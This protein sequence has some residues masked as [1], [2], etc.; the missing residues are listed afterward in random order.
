M[1]SPVGFTN[2]PAAELPVFVGVFPTSILPPFECEETVISIF[3][4][5]NI[6]TLPGPELFWWTTTSPVAI[7]VL[8]GTVPKALGLPIIIFPPTVVAL[9]SVPPTIVRFPEKPLWST[10]TLVLV[11]EAVNISFPPPFV[12]P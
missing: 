2:P 6:F 12:V 10:S 4:P 5:P 3:L 8:K 11:F 9:T 7:W 1:T